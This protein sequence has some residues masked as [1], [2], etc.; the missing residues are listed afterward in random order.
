MN[1]PKAAVG[2]L[3]MAGLMV[4]T[5]A[6]AAPTRSGAALPA[7]KTAKA[8]V[9]G[10]RSSAALK[11]TS[12]QDDEASGSTTGYVIGG[13]AAAAVIAGIIVVADDDDDSDS[14]G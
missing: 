4:S 13:L 12:A 3:T 5:A 1:I 7:V 10:I 6:V 11:R 9:K 8:P 2:A 14:P